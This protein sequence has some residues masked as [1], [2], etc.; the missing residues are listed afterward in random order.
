MYLH[1]VISSRLR[2]DKGTE[3]GD[4]ATIHAFLKNDHGDV[5]NAE[6]TIQYGPSTSNKVLCA[7][8][9]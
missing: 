9:F 8:M 7:R 5:N 6:D 4:M 1:L 2:L 3:T